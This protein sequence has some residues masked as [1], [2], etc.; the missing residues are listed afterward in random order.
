[1]KL[2]EVKIDANRPIIV[3]LLE[4]ALAGGEEVFFRPPKL[5]GPE[6]LVRVTE[7]KYGEMKMF[8]PTA[9]STLKKLYSG[10]CLKLEYKNPRDGGGWNNGTFTYADKGGDLAEW[11]LKKRKGM[12]VY[13]YLSIKDE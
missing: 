3:D 10:L 1:M 13:W 6:E 12:K 8:A 11:E 5:N 9:A 7:L 4:R 2:S